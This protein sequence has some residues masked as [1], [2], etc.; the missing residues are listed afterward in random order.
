MTCSGSSNSICAYLYN[1]AI[2]AIAGCDIKIR[3]RYASHDKMDQ[4]LLR[5]FHTA[6]NECARPGNEAKDGTDMQYLNK[7][8]I[9]SPQIYL[10]LL[11]TYIFTHQEEVSPHH[12][13]YL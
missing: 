1:T 13:R 11:L 5:E 3:L 4:A 2:F 6:S 8:R 10:L 7:S 12:T 9:T